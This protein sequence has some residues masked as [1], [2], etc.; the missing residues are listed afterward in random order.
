TMSSL[1]YGPGTDTLAVV[2]LNVQQLGDPTITAALAVLLSA[3]VVVA[4]L[5]LLALRRATGRPVG[6]E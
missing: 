5:P 6:I 3:V 1:L 2:T 4:A